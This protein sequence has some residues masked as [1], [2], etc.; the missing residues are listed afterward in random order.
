MISAIITG[1]I[2]VGIFAIVQ[3]LICKYPSKFRCRRA[4]AGAVKTIRAEQMEGTEIGGSAG[5]PE[6]TA[7]GGGAEGEEQEEI[8]TAVNKIYGGGKA[9]VV[10]K[11]QAY[12]TCS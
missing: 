8:E 1:L 2:A 6:P 3:V 11:N 7:G 4:K 10:R 12:E 9:I 5:D